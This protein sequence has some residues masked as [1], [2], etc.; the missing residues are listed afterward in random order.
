MEKNVFLR[1][2]DFNAWYNICAK[3]VYMDGRK[4]EKYPCLVIWVEVTE[5][6]SFRHTVYFECVYSNDLLMIK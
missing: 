5:Q 2:E 1:E 3:S 6:N 4:P